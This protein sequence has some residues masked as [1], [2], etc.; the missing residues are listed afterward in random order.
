MNWEL[1]DGQTEGGPFTDDDVLR[2]IRERSVPDSSQIRPVGQSQWK[3][4]RAHAPFAMALD[5]RDR[6]QMMVVAPGPYPAPPQFG[7][8]APAPQLGAYGP[9][10][11]SAPVSTSMAGIFTCPFCQYQGPPDHKSKVSSTGW[12]IFC[13]LLIFCFPLCWIGLLSTEMKRSCG[14]CKSVLATVG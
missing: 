8:Y 2:A 13:V 3:G 12:I 4:L 9:P 11:P 5:E 14:K 7:A 10:P 6:A 1:F